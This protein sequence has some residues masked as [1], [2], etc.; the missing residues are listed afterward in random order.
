MGGW[1]VQPAVVLAGDPPGPRGTQTPPVLD[2]LP[3]KRAL[4]AALLAAVDS[5]APKKA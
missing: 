3:W 4:L 2:S 1:T 5:S